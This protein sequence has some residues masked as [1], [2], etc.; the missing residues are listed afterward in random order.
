MKIPFGS[1]ICGQAASTKNTFVVQDVTKETNYLS[2]SEKTKSE[3]VVPILDN[4][5]NVFGELDIDSHKLE[6]FTIEDSNF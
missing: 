4:D 3:I 5:G 2:C 6:P 1:G